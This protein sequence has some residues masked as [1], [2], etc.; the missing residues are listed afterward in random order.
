[1]G[2]FVHG[3]IV[4]KSKR[5]FSREEPGNKPETREDKTFLMCQGIRCT[6][7]WVIWFRSPRLARSDNETGGF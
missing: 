1:M 7:Y 6:R 2:L 3:S 4:A 5:I